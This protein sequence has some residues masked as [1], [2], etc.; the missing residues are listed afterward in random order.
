MHVP[1]RPTN[2]SIGHGPFWS[3]PELFFSTPPASW[4]W[5]TY[6][7]NTNS[8]GEDDAQHELGRKWDPPKE[9]FQYI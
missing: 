1:I 9:C 7:M 8:I 3:I 4:V 6:W 5:I 2:L